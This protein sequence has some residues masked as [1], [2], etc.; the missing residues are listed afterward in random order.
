MSM[1]VAV[2]CMTQD[3]F[4]FFVERVHRP[5]GECDACFQFARMRSQPGV[6]PRSSLRDVFARPDAVPGRSPEIGV[7]G[8]MVGALQGVWRDV[9]FREVSDRITSRFEQ[10]DDVFAIGDP[11]SAEAHTHAPAQRLD[12]NNRLGSGSG[13][14]NRPM[15]PV[16]SGPCCHDNPTA[17]LHRF[18]R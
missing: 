16:E 4:V 6:L 18:N 5:P 7:L 13:T 10:Q 12:I 11:A 1:V 2:G 15:A 9:V 17:L 8:G 3:S 14:R